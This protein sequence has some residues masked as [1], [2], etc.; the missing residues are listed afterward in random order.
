[1]PTHLTV[2]G[3]RYEICDHCLKRM[4]ERGGHKEEYSI[5]P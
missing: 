4:A 1:M 3:I 2:N 5:L